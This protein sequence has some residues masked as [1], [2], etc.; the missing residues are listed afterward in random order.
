MRVQVAHA[1]FI[2]EG[3]REWVLQTL[4]GSLGADDAL[5][6]QSSRGLVPEL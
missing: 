3:V 4:D 1:S 2:A 6:V 5:G